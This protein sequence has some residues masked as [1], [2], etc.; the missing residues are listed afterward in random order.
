M[1]DPLKTG[2]AERLEAQAEARKAM[3]E[4]FKPKPAVKATEFVSRE[5][6]RAA[7]LEKVRRARAEAKEAARLKAEEAKAA[8]VQAVV[9]KEL[10][11]LERQRAERKERK[12]AAKSDARARREAKRSR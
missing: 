3:L 12:A 9:E 4:K 1:R 7:E 11:E 6:R 8:Q 5:A 2:F 10:T